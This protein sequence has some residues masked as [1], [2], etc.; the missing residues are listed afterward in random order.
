MVELA[1]QVQD[2]ALNILQ[3]TYVMLILVVPII[4]VI[5]VLV[6]VQAIV[7]VGSEADSSVWSLVAT[8][9]WPAAGRAGVP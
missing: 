7:Q 6:V 4:L 2:T 5:Q 9:D 8:D 3:I 1:K